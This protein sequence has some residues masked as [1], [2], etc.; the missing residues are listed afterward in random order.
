MNTCFIYDQFILHNLSVILYT[1]TS[2]Q[3]NFLLKVEFQSNIS[4]ENLATIRLPN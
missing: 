1:N 2:F 3:L 4:E